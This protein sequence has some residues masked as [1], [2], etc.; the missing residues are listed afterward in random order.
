VPKSA[1]NEVQWSTDDGLINPT[2]LEGAYG[3]VHLAGEGIAGGRWTEEKKR[4]IRDSRVQGTTNL[5]RDLA[6]LHRRPKVLVCA[7]AIGYYGDRGE[8]VLDESSPPGQGFLPEVC[9]Q[10]EQATAPAADAGIRVVNLR[11]GVVL[12]KH[13]GALEKMLLPFKMGVG[14]KVGSGRQY[15]SWV[16][17]ADVV[18]AILHALDCED[19]TGP[20]NV[21]SPNAVTN[22]EFTKVLGDVLHRP[23][24]LPMPALAARLALGEMANDLLLASAHVVPTQLQQTGYQF[25]FPDLRECLKHELSDKEK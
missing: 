12:S 13:G 16:A 24:W 15:W 8:E 20:V 6:S 1:V 17:H 19:L 18:G 23:T 9:R 3:I 2:K 5:C 10:W 21:V 14:G 25:Q 4:R 7:S 11:F 22:A